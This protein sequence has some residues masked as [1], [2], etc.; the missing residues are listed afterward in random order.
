MSLRASLPSLS[1]QMATG[2]Q[3]SHQLNGQARTL[4]FAGLLSCGHREVTFM[5][6]YS[7]D[8]PCLLEPAVRAATRYGPLLSSPPVGAPA[9]R[10]PSNRRNVVSHAQYVLNCPP[11]DWRRRAGRPRL[12]WLRTIELNLRPHNLGL[13]T[14]WM[15][16]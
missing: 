2:R 15:R 14:A 9:P 8:R 10:A 12:T 11:A 16:A 3:T 1:P 4:C 7:T 13:N 5:L 6:S